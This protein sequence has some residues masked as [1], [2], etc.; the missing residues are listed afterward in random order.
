MGPAPRFAHSMGYDGDRRRVVLF[1][2]HGVPADQE[3]V[4]TVL[5]DTWE[6]PIPL[7]SYRLVAITVT[8]AVVD[9]AAGQF[10]VRVTANRPI[11]ADDGALA[12][13]LFQKKNVTTGAPVRTISS[14]IPPGQTARELAFAASFPPYWSVGEWIPT[15]RLSGSPGED[16]NQVEAKLQVT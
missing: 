3:T 6:L 14:A 10:T 5:S 9:H 2:G 11:S 4:A 8:P 12:F 16:R 1:G 7:P 15:A 13:K